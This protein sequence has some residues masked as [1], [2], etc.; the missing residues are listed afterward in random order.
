MAGI[1]S[2]WRSWAPEFL[3]LLRVAAGFLFIQYGSTKLFAIPGPLMPDGSTVAPLSLAGIAGI[4]E[5]AGGVLILLGLFTRPAAFILSGE[6]AVA[7]WQAHAPKGAWPVLNHGAPAFI[8]CFV[9]LYLS[10]AG[11]GRWSLDHARR[12]RAHERKP[13]R[14]AT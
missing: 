4:L 6:M 5:L 12:S 13:T 9:F 2:R 14:V 1:T 7:Y 8:F 3:G 10:A 11:G